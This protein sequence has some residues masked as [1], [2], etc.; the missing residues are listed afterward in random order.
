M[1]DMQ[2]SYD[3]LVQKTAGEE[4]MSKRTRTSDDNIKIDLKGNN[5]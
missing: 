1:W 2:I 5:L 4:I 3:Q